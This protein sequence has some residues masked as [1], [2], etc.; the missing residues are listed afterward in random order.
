MFL[1]KAHELECLLPVAVNAQ[2][3]PNTANNGKSERTGEDL[4][5][6]GKE[7]LEE[8]VQLRAS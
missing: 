6:P 1:G 4:G 5:R 7:Y 3:R 8:I 2:L